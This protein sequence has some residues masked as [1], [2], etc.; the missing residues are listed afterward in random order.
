[1]IVSA[2][3]LGRAGVRTP[4]TWAGPLTAAC[5][6][7]AVTTPQ[8]LAGFLANVM[9]ESGG[10][11]RLVESLDY[12]V[13]GLQAT[14]PSRFPVAD[15]AR[16]GRTMTHPAD[17]LHI[18]ERAYGGRMGNRPEGNGDGFAYR[19]RGLMQLTGRDAY[20]AEAVATSRT[21]P[22]VAAWLESV[23]GA[24]ESA[25][26]HWARSGCNQLMDAGR[27]RDARSVINVGHIVPPG[28]DGSIGGLAP[29]LARYQAI[30]AM[31]MPTVRITGPTVSAVR[32]PAAAGDG[33]AATEAL[34]QASLDAGRTE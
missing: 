23:A 5:Q 18:A 25:A 4:D 2:D 29:V 9:E 7:F 28:E 34:N 17:Q 10:L 33:G 21:L 14:W 16:M 20:T 27:I 1:M 8:R 19:G 3:L 22:T 11:A 32:A 6:L 26:R 31:L 15:A 24:S 12:S 13:A 30:L